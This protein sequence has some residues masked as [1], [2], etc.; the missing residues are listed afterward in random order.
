MVK[1]EI[2]RVANLLKKAFTEKGVAVEKIIVFGSQS[3]GITHKDSDIDMLVISKDFKGK[4]IFQRAEITGSA[5]RSVMKKVLI[6]LDVIS[7]TPDEWKSGNSLIAQYAQKGE[8][9]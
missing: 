4:D 2:K 7:M 5:N 3:T 1:E 8:I 6:P 9:L